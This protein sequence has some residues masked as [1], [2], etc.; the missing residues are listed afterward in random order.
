VKEISGCDTGTGQGVAQLLDS[1]MMMMRRRSSSIKY[2]VSVK[3]DV[4]GN[5]STISRL[6]SRNSITLQKFKK[7]E[8]F[9]N[10][11]CG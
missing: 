8:S 9:I 1:Y 6:K 2:G 11:Y 5:T 10:E 3:I 7:Y 4:G